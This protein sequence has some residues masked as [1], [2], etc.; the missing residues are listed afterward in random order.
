M[1]ANRTV[2]ILGLLANLL[3]WPSLFGFAALRPDY[4]HFT[5]AVSELGVWGAPNMWAFNVL[6]LILPGLL[7]A[8]FGWTFV[9]RAAPRNWLA[10]FLLALSGLGLMLAGLSPGDMQ[11]M[12]SL[13]TIG[14]VAGAMSSLLFW[15]VA[16]LVLAVSTRKTWPALAI[17][18]LIMVLAVVATFLLYGAPHVPRAIVQRLTFAEYFG[19]Y[20]A[21]SLMLLARRERGGR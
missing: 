7:L 2:A 1:I 14:H 13:T 6:G 21:V 3:F 9:R 16:L 19:W 8:I 10:A 18:S 15:I 17:L 11:H 12:Q 4:S 5:K 20:G